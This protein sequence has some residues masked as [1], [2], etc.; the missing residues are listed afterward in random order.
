MDDIH[1]QRTYR[2]TLLIK[3]RNLCSK[4]M[5]VNPL[6]L[7]TSITI[8][9]VVLGKQKSFS[10]FSLMSI[11]SVFHVAAFSLGLVL[12][13]Q[14]IHLIGH[15]DHWVAFTVFGLLGTSCMKVFLVPEHM[16]TSEAQSW[17]KIILITLVLSFDAAAVGATSKGFIADPFTVIASVA[18]LSPIFVFLGK[19]LRRF[20]HI[21]NEQLLKLFE[22]C[23]FWSIGIGI[24]VSHTSVGF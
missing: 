17:S 20:L 13:E 5:T 4:I 18:I 24:L 2:I 21:R 23:L 15:F 1:S 6:I 11:A 12:G 10:S 14:L 19:R 9:S 3:N 16:E 8:D 7:A 22:G